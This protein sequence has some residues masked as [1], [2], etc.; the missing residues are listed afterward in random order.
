MWGPLPLGLPVILTAVH[1]PG[2]DIVSSL[3]L[4]S[5]RQKGHGCFCWQ[6]P[7]IYSWCLY[8]YID[9]YI[10]IYVYISI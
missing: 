8:I 4:C 2:D 9:I 1:I 6:P 5:G 7:H 3:G 10:Y